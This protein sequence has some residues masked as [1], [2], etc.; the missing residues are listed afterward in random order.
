VVTHIV[1]DWNGTLF[2]DICATYG[3]SCEIFAAQGLPPVTLAAYRSA[4]TRP[5]SLFYSRLFGRTFDAAEFDG[6]DQAF[7]SAYRARMIG[8]GLAEG[9]KEALT[10]WRDR[11]G[12]QSLLSMWRHDELVPFVERCGI[13][14]EFI[15]IDGLRG[16]GGGRKST[17]LARHLAAVG[18]QPPDVLLVGDSIDDAKAA[19]DVGARCVLYDGGYHN[20][21]ALETVGVP[22]VERLEQALPEAGRR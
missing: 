12:S 10:A 9:A 11:G 21:S 14:G 16:P 15:R 20:R 1:W 18:L 5:I 22:V 2:N 7:H 4:Y 13:M 3:A 6:L 8:C 17:H 19:A